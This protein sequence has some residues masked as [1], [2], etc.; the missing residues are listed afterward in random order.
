VWQS[1]FAADFAADR[2]SVDL[3]GKALVAER[4]KKGAGLD[5]KA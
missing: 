3:P 2:G 5:G 4:R 1:F